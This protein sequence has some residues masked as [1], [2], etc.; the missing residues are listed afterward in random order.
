MEY[1]VSVFK[2]SRVT[3]LGPSLGKANE[4]GL[5]LMDDIELT[6][7]SFCSCCCLSRASSSTVP[8]ELSNSPARD[9][10]ITYIFGSQG[11][12]KVPPWVTLVE[13]RLIMLPS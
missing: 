10:R 5:A 9:D 7:E 2:S 4:A 8:Q 11:Q 3:E 1:E 12:H 13:S 6:I